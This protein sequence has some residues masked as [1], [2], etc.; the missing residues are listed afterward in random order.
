MKT[1]TTISINEEILEKAK[2]AARS[3]RRSLSAQLEVWIAEKLGLELET[4]AGAAS[5]DG[6][7]EN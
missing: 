2:S 5:E 7:D 4:V 6:N 3:E 1:A